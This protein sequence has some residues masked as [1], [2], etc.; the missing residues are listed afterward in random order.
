MKA[1]IDRFLAKFISRKLLVFGAATW[2]MA[3]QYLDAETWGTVAVVYIGGQSVID[4]VLA[5]RHG[6]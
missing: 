3:M 2:L 4:T 6:K 1:L 5:W